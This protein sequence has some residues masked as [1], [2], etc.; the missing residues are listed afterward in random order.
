MTNQDV[1]EAVSILQ[2]RLKSKQK[3]FDRGVEALPNF[4]GVG[5][6]ASLKYEIEALEIILD[7]ATQVINVKMPKELKCP[8]EHTGFDTC[9]TCFGIKQY[10]QALHDFR[11]YQQKCL[12]ELEDKEIEIRKFIW[13]HHGCPI[14]M[15]YGDDGEMQCAGTGKHILDFKRMPLIDIVRIITNQEEREILEK[16][17]KKKN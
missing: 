7:L 8:L 5:R 6:W 17:S 15:L 13:V 14:H 4:D 10:N 3:E 9:L 11:L 16:F 2:D 1:K 12:G